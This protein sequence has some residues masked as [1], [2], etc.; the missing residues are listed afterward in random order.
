MKI[1]K[2]VLS[3]DYLYAFQT[4]QFLHLFMRAFSFFFF[5]F[6]FF[7]QDLVEIHPEH[8]KRPRG[9]LQHVLFLQEKN[10]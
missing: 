5:F 1:I 7:L 2:A 10:L 6:F 8:R 4:H 3:C 9:I